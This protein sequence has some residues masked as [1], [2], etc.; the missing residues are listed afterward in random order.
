MPRT[1]FR[2]FSPIQFGP[3][4]QDEESEETSSPDITRESED[5]LED[6]YTID[7]IDYDDDKSGS[8]LSSTLKSVSDEVLVFVAGACLERMSDS[9]FGRMLSS[10]DEG[11]RKQAWKL[12][13]NDLTTFSIH[14][15]CNG[16]GKEIDGSCCSEVIRYV[17]TGGFSQLIDIVKQHL[18]SIL[19][20]R[21]R[22]RDGTEKTHNLLGSYIG[23]L[24]KCVARADSLTDEDA[25]NGRHGFGRTIPRVVNY[26]YPYDTV[27]DILHNASGGIFSLVLKETLPPSPNI[28]RKSDLFQNNH[29]LHSNLCKSV[30]LPKEFD[31]RNIT[32]CSEKITFF[33][34]S[35]GLSALVNPSLKDEARMVICSLMLLKNSFYTNVPVINTRFYK[36]LCDSARWGLEQASQHYLATKAHELLSHLPEVVDKFGNIACLSTFCS[37]QRR[38]ESP[39]NSPVSTSVRGT[40]ARGRSR[41]R[42]GRLHQSTPSSLS[43]NSL[44]RTIG[45][46]A[47]ESDSP[48][49]PVSGRTSS[50]SST[51]TSRKTSRR[52]NNGADVGT[53]QRGTTRGKSRGSRGPRLGLRGSARGT[54]SSI[55]LGKN[56]AENNN[57]RGS[58]Q[59]SGAAGRSV[60][61]RGRPRGRA[62]G[63]VPIRE[64][65]AYFRLLLHSG[66]SR[67]I[68]QR[69]TNSPSSSIN[70]FLRFTPSLKLFQ[71]SW[72]NLIKEVKPEDAVQEL[73]DFSLYATFTLSLGRLES[74][75]REGSVSNQIFFAVNNDGVHCCYKFIYVAVHGV[76][77]YI[78]AEKIRSIC[79][80]EQFNLLKQVADNLPRPF[81]TFGETL[82]NQFKRYRGIVHGKPS[83]ER[84][85]VSFDSIRGVGAYIPDGYYLQL[86]GACVHH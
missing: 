57:R 86:N 21:E 45:V 36:H 35:F 41:S 48:P 33:R 68:Q 47:T 82:L 40:S 24:W 44:N 31:I 46:S 42:G 14:E 22:L 4:P 69:D 38:R 80:I 3:G 51:G 65:T 39:E 43:Q 70:E 67:E 56:T 55:T 32:N 63:S 19:S 83:G 60:P 29:N 20:I 61:G 53:N 18:E 49:H 37:I 27:I 10:Q 1:P 54:V 15:V 17:R 77:V 64:S 59:N 28:K 58:T 72:R 73:A 78:Y 23:R 9:G 26:C 34:T 8:D 11:F 75:Y 13:K 16:C 30:E 76:D 6:P 85:V 84:E 7:D 62:L 74:V 79:G 71:P 2:L 66:I 5:T 52:I 25:A 81:N 50:A 12:W